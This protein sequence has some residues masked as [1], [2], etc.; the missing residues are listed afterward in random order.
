MDVIARNAKRLQRL[1]EEILDVTKIESQSLKLK[2]EEFNLN[3]VI[4]NCINDI[5]MNLLLRQE[6]RRKNS[7]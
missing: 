3:N 2:K 6:K 4:I 5:T 1:T 7:L